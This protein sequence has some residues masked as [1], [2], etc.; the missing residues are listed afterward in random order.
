MFLELGL[1]C[2]DLVQHIETEGQD[3]DYLDRDLS[4]LFVR[5]M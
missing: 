1:E 2:A 5:R 4:D 3:L